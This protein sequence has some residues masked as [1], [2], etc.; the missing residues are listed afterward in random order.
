M[1]SKDKRSITSPINGFN[2]G[3]KTPEGKAISSQNAKKHGIFAN[4]QTAFDDMSFDEAYALLALEY[5]DDTLTRQFLISQLAILFIRLRRCARFENEFLR[6][7]LNP[8]RYEEK[9]IKAAI[10]IDND[11]ESVVERVLVNK[12]EPATID[13]SSLDKLDNVY[14]KYEQHFLSRFCQIVQMLTRSDI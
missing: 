14:V 10:T 9:V 7:Q 1:E 2:G 13:V 4:Y 6:E 12:G 3:V 11:F 5:G 8:P